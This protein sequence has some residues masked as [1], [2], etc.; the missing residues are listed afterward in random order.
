[1]EAPEELPESENSTKI[2]AGDA[3]RVFYILENAKTNL[4]LRMTTYLDLASIVGLMMVPGFNKVFGRALREH[5][6]ISK[7]KYKKKGNDVL[8]VFYNCVLLDAGGGSVVAG[9]G[10]RGCADKVISFLMKAL[11]MGTQS[12]SQYILSKVGLSVYFPPIFAGAAA[13][14]LSAK[15]AKKVVM[16]F[17][18]CE[19]AT[20][21]IDFKITPQ[22]TQKTFTYLQ[23]DCH[24]VSASE[25]CFYY[26]M[27]THGSQKNFPRT[28]GG[29][30]EDRCWYGL[31]L[32]K[33]RYYSFLSIWQTSHLQKSMRMYLY[34]SF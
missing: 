4:L 14:Y 10:Y 31:C 1:M 33:Y 16:S 26:F 21:N 13:Q 23:Q 25:K 8:S 20:N 15:V 29:G 9:G 22:E 32:Q 19:G 2:S 6:L 11:R 3:Q 5:P 18:R 34:C 27:K 12:S 30:G 28:F 17:K 24:L 7:K